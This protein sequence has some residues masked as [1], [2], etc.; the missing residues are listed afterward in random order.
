[1]K[2]L[3]IVALIFLSSCQKN[4][5]DDVTTPIDLKGK[6]VF[7]SGRN[8]NSSDFQLFLMNANG[9]D[10]KLISNQ[11]VD[12]HPPVLSHNK[13]KIVFTVYENL[14]NS[15]YVV[16]VDGQNLKLLDQAKENCG[17][18]VWLPDDSK[19]TFMRSGVAPNYNCNLFTINIDGTN[20]IQLTTQNDNYSPNYLPNNS[21]I[22]YST[23][24]G[25]MSKIYKMNTDGT[26]KQ[27]LSP[28]GKSFSASSISPDG[29]MIAIN[30][31]DWNGTQ[32]FVMNI[33]GSGLKQ[34]TFTVDKNYYDTGFPRG[35]TENPVWSPDGSRIA[36]VSFENSNPDIFAIN[37]N[38]SGNK[39]LTDNPLRDESPSWTSDGNYI[40]FSAGKT[41]YSG[42]TPTYGG[43]V[44][45]I[46]RPDGQ[47]KTPITDNQVSD[48]YPTFIPN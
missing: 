20:K 12:C 1:M 27:L 4:I 47:S 31:A 5:T 16:D 19:I 2:Q 46:M 30:S 26:N 28:P 10:Q 25:T 29:K 3:F 34:L 15:L 13:K 21:A 8:P 33:D 39:R 43:H 22:I 37:A 11:M 9:T 6:I 7:V 24:D 32:I 18:P 17:N 44:I 36:Y 23:F 42:G 45:C 35:G 48:I 40:I 41:W 38:G 14:Y